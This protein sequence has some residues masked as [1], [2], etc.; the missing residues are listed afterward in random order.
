MLRKL[1]FQMIDDT[2]AADFATIESSVNILGPLV[3]KA[4]ITVDSLYLL[5]A[6][7]EPV[8]SPRTDFYCGTPV[9]VL[10]FTELPPGKCAMIILHATGVPR[11]K[12]IS[13]ILS[14]KG[15]H[16]WLLFGFSTRPMIEAGRDG[17]GYWTAAREYA[18]KSMTWNAWFYYRVAAYL[19]DPVEFLTSSNLEKLKHEEER[20]RPDTLPSTK[21]M[22]LDPHGS[23]F[24]VTAI[25]T[26][27]TLGPLDLE[28]HY[29]PDAAQAKLLHDPPVARKQVTDLMTAL[30]ELHPELKEAFHG[31]WVYADLGSA[32]LFF[33]E[34]PMDQI[35]PKTQGPATIQAPVAN[36]WMARTS[37]RVKRSH[38]NPRLLSA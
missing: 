27:A 19:L 10:N 22:M 6:L 11:P 28:V 2:V 21:P 35:V 23:A 30:L 31:V 16:R 17:L 38:M 13:L 29:T 37:E 9:V 4:A 1:R 14:E 8:G 12:Q 25:D 15:A 20:V 7:A 33:L 26:A 5:D 34:L 36:R 3:Q 18:Q 32:S 24:Q